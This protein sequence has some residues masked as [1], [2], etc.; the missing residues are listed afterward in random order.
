VMALERGKVATALGHKSDARRCFQLV[1][2]AWAR[3]DPG[4]RTLVA[5]AQKGLSRL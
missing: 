4:A 2:Q 3:G 5:E 1:V